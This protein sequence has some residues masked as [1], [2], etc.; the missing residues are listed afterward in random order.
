M[1]KIILMHIIIF[2]NCSEDDDK[3]KELISF[4]LSSDTDNKLSAND[5]YFK[6]ARNK[7]IAITI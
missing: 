6:T 5:H 1:Q 7:L 3:R 2:A 4:D